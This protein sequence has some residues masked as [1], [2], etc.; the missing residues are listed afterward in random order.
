M[1]HCKDASDE[2]QCQLVVPSIGYDKHLIPPPL[3]EDQHQYVNVS[4]DIKHIIFINEAENFIRITYNIQKDW[5]DSS[6][7]FQNLKKDTINSLSEDEK[8]IIWVPFI[9]FINMESGDKERRANKVEI[10]KVVPNKDFDYDHNK[11]TSYKNAH[12]FKVLY[13]KTLS[14]CCF[15]VLNREM[16]NINHLYHCRAATIT[17]LIIGHGQQILF[18]LF[19]IIGFLLIHKLVK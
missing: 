7:S 12:I 2:Q 18:A 10:L 5:F 19:N 16:S 13:I 15:I 8:D 11:N 17:S 6:L 4:L 3:A 1:I 14:V 9:L